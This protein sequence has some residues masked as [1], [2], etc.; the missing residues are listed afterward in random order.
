M[1]GKDN[2][3]DVESRGPD[4]RKET[5]SSR[6]FAGHAFLLQREELWTS[7]TVVTCKGDDDAEIKKNVKVNA[8]QLENDIL[9]NVEKRVSNWCKWKRIIVLVLI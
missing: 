5:S 8:V 2:P 6:W 7:Y 3:A 9:E 4:P 1:K